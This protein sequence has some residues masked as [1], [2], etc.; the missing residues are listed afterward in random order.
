MSAT[1][2]GCACTDNPLLLTQVYIQTD[3]AVSV[4]QTMITSPWLQDTTVRDGQAYP[5]VNAVAN[6]DYHPQFHIFCG[7][8]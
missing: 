4:I 5:T 8:N 6:A 3:L 7:R 1:T 2:D